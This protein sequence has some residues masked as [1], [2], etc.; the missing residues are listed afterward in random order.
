M[1]YCSGNKDLIA[2]IERE[3]G[4]GAYTQTDLSKIRV[5]PTGPQPPATIAASYS[6]AGRI[7]IRS[8]GMSAME[9]RATAGATGATVSFYT[10]GRLE[11][12]DPEDVKFAQRTTGIRNKNLATSM[13]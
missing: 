4:G 2:R 8:G 9:A 7:N 10:E 6:R 5:I 1:V 3:F 11:F 13:L 12:P